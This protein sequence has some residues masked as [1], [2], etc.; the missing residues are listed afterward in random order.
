MNMNQRVSYHWLLIPMDSHSLLVHIFQSLSHS[1]N[2]IL[3]CQFIIDE[4]CAHSVSHDF[5][6]TEVHRNLLEMVL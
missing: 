3:I 5:N 6:L 4:R 1:T 2:L